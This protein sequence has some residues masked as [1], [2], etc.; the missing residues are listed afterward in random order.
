[1]GQTNRE[2]KAAA[3]KKARQKRVSAGWAGYQFDDDDEVTIGGT[4]CGGIWADWAKQQQKDLPPDEFKAIQRS[5]REKMVRDRWASDPNAADEMYSV[6]TA[7]LMSMPKD[8]VV[9]LRAICDDKS[10]S[11]ADRY[12]R[13]VE[14]SGRYEYD[15][16]MNEAFLGGADA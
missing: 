13:V 14:F 1:M 8:R 5:M 3:K 16:I 6:S 7:E 15:L 12:A 2:K 10:A 9:E 11:R 4:T